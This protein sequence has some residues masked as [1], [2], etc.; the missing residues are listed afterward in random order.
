MKVNFQD[1]LVNILQVDIR[2][3]PFLRPVST[4]VVVMTNLMKLSDLRFPLKAA[5]MVAGQCGGAVLAAGTKS[6]LLIFIL[7]KKDIIRPQ[8]PNPFF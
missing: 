5:A 3:S 8:V 4:V 6:I 1:V 2:R 7:A